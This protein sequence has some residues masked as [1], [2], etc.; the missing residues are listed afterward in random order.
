MVGVALGAGV[1]LV[2]FAPAAWL[3]SAVSDA[4]GRRVLLA[5]ARGTVWQGSAVMVLTGGV[6]SRDA[7][8]LPGRLNWRLGLQGTALG[9]HAQQ[10]CCI[11]GELLL[12][13]V[14]G[15]SSFRIELPA[16]LPVPN[17]APAVASATP[18]PSTNNLPV[19]NPTVSNPTAS[20]PTASN[21]PVSTVVGQW[22]ASWLVGLG[23]PWN[24]L[25]P[26]GVLQLSSSGL[27]AEQVQGRWRFKGNAV[28]AMDGMASRMSTLDTLGSYRLS[29]NADTEGGDTTRL[30]LS[31][32]RGAL[33]L[34]GDGQ[35]LQV[36]AATKLRFK[37]QASA[38]AGSEAALGGLLNVIGQ[39]QG[40]LSVISIG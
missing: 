18:L 22:P 35:V 4:T 10:D 14:P 9:L 38:A 36:G 6:D 40:A 25:Q 26:S 15:W 21:L 5:D 11:Q 1:A 27:V 12:R 13:L 8:A 3:A 37:G 2:A 29:L 16:T 34:S 33:Q 30:Q 32:T 23:T 7:S 24:T 20:N 28:L 31:T 39:R 17:P 19:S